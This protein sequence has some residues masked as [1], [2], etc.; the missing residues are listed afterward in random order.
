MKL[1]LKEDNIY[2]GRYNLSNVT[3]LGDLISII[4]S[5]S[6]LKVKLT[7]IEG[8]SVEKYASKLKKTIGIDSARFVDRCKSDYIKKNYWQRMDS[9]PVDFP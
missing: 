2:A 6:G 8:W 5:A 1:T 7:F 3:Q 9:P 4:T